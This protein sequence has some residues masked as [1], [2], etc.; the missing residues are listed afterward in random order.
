MQQQYQV[1]RFF[2]YDVALGLLASPIKLFLSKL[3]PEMQYNI[4][5]H[6]NH[7]RNLDSSL[8][9]ASI[10]EV[11]EAVQYN[12][13][14]LTEIMPQPCDAEKKNIFFF[15]PIKQLETLAQGVKTNNILFNK[16]Q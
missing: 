8:S 1:E 13:I 7:I 3:F 12:D 9:D 6:K 5:Y 16:L 2:V 14:L 10:K 11:L 15:K 4:V